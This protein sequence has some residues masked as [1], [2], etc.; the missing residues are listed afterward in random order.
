MPLDMYIVLGL[1][2]FWK[3]RMAVR[4]ADPFVRTLLGYLLDMI[5]L[6]K[7]VVQ[8]MEAAPEWAS[9]FDN[10]LTMREFRRY[11]DFAF[12]QP[13]CLGIITRLKFMQ[14]LEI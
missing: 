14:L 2:S 6:I 8:S 5:L 1:F 12:D 10:L 4:H 9:L 3:S 7:S 13:F 11:Y